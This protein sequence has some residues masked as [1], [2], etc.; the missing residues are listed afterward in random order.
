MASSADFHY[1][2]VDMDLDMAYLETDTMDNN[3]FPTVSI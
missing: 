3:V 1:Q 2:D